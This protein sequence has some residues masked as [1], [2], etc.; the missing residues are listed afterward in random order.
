MHDMNSRKQ[1]IGYCAVGDMASFPVEF[2]ERIR[3]EGLKD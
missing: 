3:T 1:T 2:L